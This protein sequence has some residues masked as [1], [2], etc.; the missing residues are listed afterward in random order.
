MNSTNR[1]LNRAVLIVCAMLLAVAGVAALLWALRPAPAEH[2]MVKIERTVAAVV[3]DLSQS[4]VAIPG[5]GALPTALIV[6][7]LAALILAVA[8]TIFVFA[9]GGGDVRDVA[10]IRASDGRTDVD[11]DVVGA[12]LNG[13]LSARRDVLYSRT[14]VY[15][16][17]GTRTVRLAVVVCP[18]ASLRDVLAAAERAIQD[19]DSLL[20]GESPVLIHLTDR[21]WLNR[22]RSAIRVR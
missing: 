20:G 14:G 6:T 21:G 17:K 9:R 8:L 5:A 15:L 12:V 1:T 11:R 19:W 4:T 13:A 2:A 22:Y 10:Q 16:V 3:S 7:F 18:G